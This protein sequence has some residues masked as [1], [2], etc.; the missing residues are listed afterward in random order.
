MEKLKIIFNAGYLTDEI[1]TLSKTLKLN[2]FTN[3]K[4]IVKDVFNYLDK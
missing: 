4:D 1:I 3:E 2:E